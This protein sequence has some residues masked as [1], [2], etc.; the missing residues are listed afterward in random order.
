MGQGVARSPDKTGPH[1]GFQSSTQTKN[2]P[3]IRGVFML[4]PVQALLI[5]SSIFGFTLDAAYAKAC[6]SE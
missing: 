1:P 2:A 3:S 6:L 4:W 5:L